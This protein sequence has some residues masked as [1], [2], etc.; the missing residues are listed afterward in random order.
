MKSDKGIECS[1]TIPFPSFLPSA[2]RK[3][4]VSAICI[5]PL[6]SEVS[7]NPD[8]PII[9]S[10]VFRSFDLCCAKLIFCFA[11]CINWSSKL[12]FSGGFTSAFLG[13]SPLICYELSLPLSFWLIPT[14]L[15]V[16]NA[17]YTLFR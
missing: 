13:T 7:C 17:S 4:Q 5:P 8:R 12:D 3:L 9:W 14:S 16:S 11:S 1:L 10:G 6:F 2:C 15:S